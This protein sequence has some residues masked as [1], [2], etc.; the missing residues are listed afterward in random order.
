MY[1]LTQEHRPYDRR[2]GF[3]GQPIPLENF[4][5]VRDE[6][7]RIISGRGAWQ[8]GVRYSQVDFTDSGVPGGLVRDVTLGVNW[9]LNPNLKFQWNF[10]INER[11]IPGLASNG[12]VYG[13]GM[14]TALQF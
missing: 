7:N 4:F 5:M 2:M 12:F 9:Y 1:F 10:T 11:E 13:A 6:N 3:L 8:V 14:R